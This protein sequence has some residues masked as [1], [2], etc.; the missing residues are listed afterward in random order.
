M[1]RVPDAESVVFTVLVKTG[2]RYESKD[3]CGLAHFLEHVFFKGSEANPAPAAISGIIDSIGGDINASTSKEFTEFYVKAQKH[4]FDLVFE[5][6]TDMI[7]RPIFQDKELEKEKGVVF[8]E[9]NLYQDNPAA[10]ADS[11]L[12]KIMWPKSSLGWEILGTKK[13]IKNLN[14]NKVIEFKERYYQPSNLI[15]GVCGSFDQKAVVNKVKKMWN[16]EQKSA[17]PKMPAL[18]D[19]Q[20]SPRLNIEHKKTQ[21]V[22]F[23]LGFKSFGHDDQHNPATFLLG[24]ILGGSTSSRLWLDI[25]EEKGWAYYVRASNIPYFHAGVFSISAGVKVDSTVE[26][27]RSIFTELRR[28]KSDMISELELQKAKDYIK[29]RIALGLEDSQEKL[30]WFMERY[31]VCDKVKT[32]TDFFKQIDRVSA[33][34]IQEVAKNIFQS[35]SMSLAMVGPLKQKEIEKE[36]Y[37]NSNF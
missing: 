20:R 24:A 32:P 21:Q 9:M 3:L 10:Q 23:A 18:Q 28:I 36:F 37:S 11:I 27:L 2:S 15:L 12:D 25:R 7:N 8:E 5:T 6:L 13:S 34:Q 22:H 4:Q 31:A 35:K 17:I 14:R 16:T 26:V 19:Q 30:N 29:G 33:K 1:V